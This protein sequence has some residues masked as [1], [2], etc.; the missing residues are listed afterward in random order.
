MSTLISATL[1]INSCLMILA[2]YAVA[3]SHEMCAGA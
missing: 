1:P 2:F 3:E